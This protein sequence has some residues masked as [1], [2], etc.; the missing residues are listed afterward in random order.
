MK[1][2]TY[3]LILTAI[4]VGMGQIANGQTGLQL[5]QQFQ[6]SSSLNPAF[7]GIDNYLDIKAGFRQ[8]WS[9]ISDG[10]RVYYLTMNSVL[11]KPK[12]QS[13]KSNAL[14]ISDP[15]LYSESESNQ[16][17]RLSAIKHGIG[18]SIINDSYGP[19]NQLNAYLSYGFHFPLTK[20]LRLSLGAAGGIVNTQINKEKIRVDE[21]FEAFDETYQA[22]LSHGGESAQF[23]MNAGV[24][25]YHKDFYVGYSAANLMQNVLITGLSEEKTAILHSFMAGLKFRLG[26]DYQILPSVVYQITEPFEAFMN[27]GLKL[28]YRNSFWGGV[29]YRDNKDLIVM[30]GFYLNNGLNIGYSYDFALNGINDQLKGSH[31]VVIGISIFN[32]SSSI[33]YAW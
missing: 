20:K 10:P 9:G 11:I 30:T 6:N 1:R 28:R 21:E 14:R 31:E 8:Q 15:S 5:S 7:A 17:N 26:S 24:L 22:F 13:I 16:F 19:F 4:L 3:F 23:N 12:Y 18:A 2:E 25:L 27:Y 29:S 32:E 33:P